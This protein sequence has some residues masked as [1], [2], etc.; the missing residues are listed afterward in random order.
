MI[1]MDIIHTIQTHVQQALQELYELSVDSPTILINVTKKSFDGDYT[2]VIFPFVKTLRKKP[3][4]IG[5]EIGEWLK[6]NTE[7]VTDFNCIQG[8]LNLSLADQ[9]WLDQTNDLINHP[10]YWKKPSHGKK[11]IVEFSSPNTNKPLHLGHIRNILLG[12]SCSKLYEAIGYDVIKTQII[13]DRGIAVCKS[14]LAWKKFADGRTPQSEEV[15]PDH[16]VGDWYVRFEQEFQKEYKGWQQGTEAEEIYN[17]QQKEFESPEAFF[18]RYK[19][20]YFNRYSNLG[21]EAREM[22]KKW[23]AGNAETRNL[24]EQMNGWVYSGFNATYDA[25]GVSFDT[26]YY[27][28]NTYL[29]GKDL[30]AK[31]LSDGIFF[32]KEDGS[33]WVDLSDDGMDEKILLRSDGTSVYMTQDLGTANLRFEDYGPERMVYVVGDEQ[34]YHFKALFKILKKLGVSY[35]DGLYHLSYGMIDLPSGR[36]KSREG[37]VVDADDLIADV[38][39]EAD[40]GISER[41]EVVDLTEEEQKEITRRIGIAALKFF[42]IKIDPQKRMIFDPKASVDLQGQTGPY[43]QNAFVRIQSIL[44]KA[45]S[46]DDAA[47]AIYTVNADE[48]SLLVELSSFPYIIESAALQFDPSSVANFCYNLA[49]EFHRYYHEHRILKAETASA[50]I[51]RLRFIQLI[52]DVLENGMLL[53]GIEMPDRM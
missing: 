27:E 28:S 9:F 22:L 6:A 23:E 1:G 33:V 14:M 8:F 53:L 36:M 20:E 25:L 44:R 10:D 49:K 7:V 41:G 31:G 32:K 13:N 5:S 34:N 12:W 52:S 30:I 24:W 48:K 43:I 17:D 3:L 4:D 2:V 11:I 46:T 45:N 15:K 21:L 51:Y 18:K 40:K 16:F 42:M 19:N 37:T 29:L 39:K 47:E 26:L 38:I 35:A 50:R